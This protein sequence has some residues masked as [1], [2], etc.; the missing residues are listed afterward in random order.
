M[1]D[2]RIAVLDGQPPTSKRAGSP[3]GPTTQRSGQGERPADPTRAVGRARRRHDAISNARLVV[4][5]GAGHLAPGPA[6]AG[7]QGSPGVVARL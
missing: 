6:R 4:V 1:P 5:A 2:A 7:D 3:P